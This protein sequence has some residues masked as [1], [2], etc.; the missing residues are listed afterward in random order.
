MGANLVAIAGT[1]L[2]P[3][4][5]HDTTRPAEPPSSGFGYER[6]SDLFGYNR[7]QGLSLGLGYH[8]PLPGPHPTSV[9]ATVRYGVSDERVTWRVSAYRELRNSTLRLSGYYE[10]VSLDPVSPGRNFTN[11]INSLFAGHDN[12]DYAVSRGA[13]AMW[14]TRLGTMLL[15]DLG[16]RIERQ[17]STGGTAES[18]INDFLGGTGLF[19]PNPPV[20]EATFVG[21][22]GRLSGRG[23]L[24]WNL[25]FDVLGGSGH[26]V[27][28]LL[29]DVRRTIGSGPRLTLQ[30]K[31]GAG[32]EPGLPQT[33]FRL[34]GLNTV[35]GF[36]YGTLRGSAFWAAQADVALFGGRVRPLLFLDVGQTSALDELVSS[37]ALVGA[38]AGLALF[39]G[40]VRFEL[41]RPV[42]P[43]VGGK[44]RFDIVLQGP[45]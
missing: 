16:S 35:R 4:L 10:L 3:S 13:S 22:S 11:T 30:V 26:T 20:R 1:L 40:L 34:G 27:A 31:A 14:E 25:T 29:G 45:M 15:L 19:P 24:K 39:K 23:R 33:L 41:S 18:A 21:A 17:N 43:D 8:V 42:S 6:L 7:V 9:Y 36:E 2:L 32:T 44:L 37:T 12:S 5:Q 38:G 28:R